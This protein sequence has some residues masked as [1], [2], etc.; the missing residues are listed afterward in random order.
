M[1]T[2]TTFK[3]I[4]LVAVA[5]LGM[6][7]LS[8]VPASAAA[9]YTASATLSTTS[10]TVVGGV[11]G[12]SGMGY[13]RI[14]T[15]DNAGDPNILFATTESITVSVIAVPANTAGDATAPAT[16]DITLTA[17]TRADTT[18]VVTS[19]GAA[20]TTNL[21]IPNGALTTTTAAS[22]DLAYYPLAADGTTVRTTDSLASY[23]VGVYP[24]SGKAVDK[25]EY[26]IRVL[27]HDSTGFE[28]TQTM[29]VKFVTAA[30][31]SGAVITVASAGALYNLQALSYT[32]SNYVKAT[33][34]DANGGRI[35]LGGASG[36]AATTFVP[37]LQGVLVSSAGVVGDSL[38]PADTG[39][40]ATDRVANLTS[41]STD[42][43]NRNTY[44][45]LNAAAD[46]VYGLTDSSIT[47]AASTTTTIR[48][49]YGSA[50]TSAAIVIYGATAV[51][52]N[53]TDLT[54]TATGVLASDQLIKS[55]V[56]T[57]TAYTLPAT[58][59]SAKLRINVDSTAAA[60]VAD[61]PVTVKTVWTGNYATAS[62]SPVTA[63]T[64]TS[65]SDASGNVDLTIT[66]S[67]PLA[68]AVATI[69]ITGFGFGGS[70]SAGGGSRIVTLTWAAAKA[71]TITAIDPVAAVK[72]KTATT[73]VVTVSVKDQFG[74]LMAG[75]SLQPSLDSDSSNYAASTTYA[76]ITTG[77]AGTAT[78][79]LTDA[80]AAAGSDNISF[81][82][83]S[84][85]AAT[86]GSFT[87]TYVTT[88]PV[89]ATISGYYSHTFASPGSYSLVPS[90]GIYGTTNSQK[91]T[92]EN[93]RNL[94][95]SLAAYATG[96][97][98]TNDDMVAVQIKAVTS[99][100]ASATGAAVTLTAPTGA[101]VLDAS[102]LPAASRTIAVASSVAS[103]QVL[104]TVAGD[105]TFTATSGTVSTTITLH[106]ATPAA[107]AGRT[108]AITGGTTGTANGAGV[109]M[110]VTVKDRYGNAVTGVNLTLSAT[111]V[112]AFAGGATTQSFTT[113]SSGTYTF[114]AKSFTAAGGAGTFKVSAS[115][116]TDASS[117][118]GYVAAT[119]VDSTLAAGV[120]SAS[121][122]VT[123]G[124]GE[125][126]AAANAQA[127][128]D[129]A[130]EATDAANAATDAANAAA[131]AA[132]AATAAAQDAADAVAALSAQVASLISGLKAQLT[133]LTN[134]V[135]KIQK[136]VKA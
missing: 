44:T 103:F 66:N 9:T 45:A 113:D 129:A 119:V 84:N 49:R 20:S 7:V 52:D 95:K 118:A 37:G 17:M 82:S 122:T 28:S 68:G 6:G 75:E 124:A 92:I 109:P 18:N 130:A 33:L 31:D 5:A 27:L 125:D 10:L 46:G 105:L 65:N 76:A 73:N 116:A 55:D 38:A 83:V 121:A 106:A 4:A 48:V 51:L 54:L 94:L 91:L 99:T 74:N 62:V 77:A 88:L 59:T 3:R 136:K 56:A 15:T 81:A 117:N 39:V 112:G 53:L 41:A 57:T 108:V 12:A 85:S 1:S 26:T 43:A 8:I 60:N 14:S 97:D 107:A 34:K 114:E 30:A 104:A 132:D 127:A 42:Y 98:P 23:Y 89:V 90:T 47:N 86:A 93:G 32:S 79:S 58:T 80:T 70:D 126:A 35:Q 120:S 2:K 67:A 50:S 25:G 40:A 131:E 78:F 135:I 133:A 87:L 11:T 61:Q 19:V 13:F 134:L 96:D 24:T 102:G 123:F 72:V 100:G 111:G 21:Q 36:G 115:N 69:T 64:T 22:R 101:W 63:T 16:S 110:T 128:T 71:T 29:K